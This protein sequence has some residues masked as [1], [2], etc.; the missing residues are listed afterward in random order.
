[1]SEATYPSGYGSRLDT[2]EQVRDRHQ[3]DYHPEAWRRI[4]AAMVN[5]QGLLGLADDQGLCGIGGGARTREQQ[6]ANYAEDPNT[7]APPDRSFHQIWDIW[8]DGETGAQA[9]DWVGRDGRHQEAWAWLRDNGGLYGLKTFHN[10]NGEPWHSQMIGVP[11]SVSSW[12]KAGH[13]GP[14]TWDL[15]A[16]PPPPPP[17]PPEVE[18]GSDGDFGLYPYNQNK[19]ALRDGAVGNLVRYLQGVMKFRADQDHIAVDGDFGPQTEAAVVQV[20][21]YTGVDPPT[22][23]VE[24]STWHIIDFLAGYIP[25]P[26]VTDDV[27]DVEDGLYIVRKG[28]SPW[29]VGDI[30]YGSG[31][32]GV[33]LLDADEFDSYGHQIGVP[34]LPGRVTKVKVD[35]GPLATISRMYPGENQ[36]ALLD[37]FYELNGGENRV[38][39]PE[40]LVFLDT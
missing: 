21:L 32:K 11:N 2:L 23:V 1:M 9:I 29:R 15:G 27:V 30:C 22:G 20:Q 39:H 10:V 37:R 38:H 16:V 8:A 7:F 33:D 12:R 24:D 3:A 35:E 18:F 34:E 19:P 25:P 17:P 5:A 4:E 26:P 31:Q 13:P 40:D 36:Y 28:D 6:A 14:E